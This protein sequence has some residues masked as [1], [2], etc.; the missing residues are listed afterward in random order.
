LFVLCVPF[1]FECFRSTLV[2][3]VVPRVGSLSLTEDFNSKTGC[4]NLRRTVE[5]PEICAESPVNSEEN[6]FALDV[7]FGGTPG[8]TTHNKPKKGYRIVHLFRW[9]AHLF[10]FVRHFYQKDAR[11]FR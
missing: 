3:A 4:H 5:N 6:I 9:V 2:S 11:F 1:N 7:S 10:R 8:Q